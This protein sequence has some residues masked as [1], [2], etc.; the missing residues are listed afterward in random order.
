MFKSFSKDDLFMA[1]WVALVILIFT[2]FAHGAEAS[3]EKAKHPGEQ[4]K[5][6]SNL[7]VYIHFSQGSQSKKRSIGDRKDELTEQCKI[8][9]KQAD[10]LFDEHDMSE[11]GSISDLIEACKI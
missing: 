1:M 4:P 3:T 7:C 5:I 9:S 8:S 11:V 2:G 10:C 6:S